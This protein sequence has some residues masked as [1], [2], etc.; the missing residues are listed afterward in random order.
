MVN[1]HWLQL[2]L[3][4]AS[5]LNKRLSLSFESLKP[6]IGF[7]VLATKVLDDHLLSI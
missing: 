3:P 6:D 7:S 4:S 5:A 1:K 2:Q